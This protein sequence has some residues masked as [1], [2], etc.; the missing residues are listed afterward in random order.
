MATPY[1][2]SVSYSPSQQILGF[3]PQR[4]A[5]EIAQ[6]DNSMMQLAQ[7]SKTLGGE[8]MK[9]QEQVN[10]E[11][12]MEGYNLAL[13][14]PNATDVSNEIRQAGE[15]LKADDMDANTVAFDI[16]K[17]GES[18][19]VAQ[20][21]QNMSGWKRYGYAKGKAEQA[22]AGWL[23][24][25]SGQFLNNRDKT[26]S[27]PETGQEFTLADT[28]TDPALR[29]YA[30]T[31]MR[32][33]Y[34]EE[35]GLLTMKPAFLNEWA[36]EKFR[37]GQDKFVEE[38]RQARVV[39]RGQEISNQA[40]N[41]V[42]G[43]LDLNKYFSNKKVSYNDKGK[44]TTMNEA[45]N[46]L[47][48][49]FKDKQQLTKRAVDVDALR[50][51]P[52]AGD[53]K[54]RTYGDLYKAKLDGLEADLE[55]DYRQIQNNI[56]SDNSKRAKDAVDVILENCKNN[57]ACT[58]QA[59]Q[60]T[61]AD[62]NSTY[63]ATAASEA[64]KFL[65][66][67]YPSNVELDE[68]ES[69]SLL[70]QADDAL[71]LG[72]MT[73]PFYRSLPESI[74]QLPEVQER[75]SEQKRL[76]AVYGDVIS[77][78]ETSIANLFAPTVSGGGI[79]ASSYANDVIT[80]EQRKFKRGLV[81]QFRDGNQDI[82]G[83][84]AN[85][86]RQLQ[87]DYAADQTN[88]KGTYYRDNRNAGV[89]YPNYFKNRASFSQES[90]AGRQQYIADSPALKLQ[91]KRELLTKEVL[92]QF[93]KQ[94]E[95][96]PFLLSVNQES[97]EKLF[98]SLNALRNIAAVDQTTV[99]QILQDINGMLDAPV[100]LPPIPTINRS[101]ANDALGGSLL[102][103]FMNGTL[104]QR[105]SERVK[106]IVKYPTYVNPNL[107]QQEQQIVNIIGKYESDALGGY[108]AVNQRG[109]NKG[110]SVAGYS[111]PFSQMSQHGGRKLTELTVGEIMELQS[112]DGSL[113]NDQWEQ[114]GKL[115]AVGR[116]QFIGKTLAE[117]VNKMGI[118]KDALFSPELQDQ[119]CLFHFREK[120]YGPWVG[121]V[122][123]G[124]QTEKM[125]LN[126]ARI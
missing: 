117:V 88:D 101:A 6:K 27:H 16:I 110:R 25:L 50:T 36:G 113:T 75:Y 62:I 42:L 9:Y 125:F 2:E 92:E 64:V 63:G 85:Y 66:D 89:P 96:D 70:R 69:Q 72:E 111:G 93:A 105:Q 73:D 115:H 121:V 80:E 58:P 22:G 33:D 124:S 23:S 13:S 10:K 90:E 38:A 118:S 26:F 53:P 43:D 81:Q 7:F 78:N 24:Y 104:T 37:S 61:I 67:Q 57:P 82:I 28:E 123:G 1:E 54:G 65:T 122:D 30:I 60:D 84:A 76:N 59:L 99:H 112:D 31:E 48:E 15:Q 103:K 17:G 119:M 21:V 29:A 4:A 126:R 51:Q 35:N 34:L 77:A 71:D 94:M 18:P 91:A 12:M 55:T 32:K 3:S 40:E 98:Y 47:T 109:T 39:Q 52:I 20:A 83:W 11:Q 106:A 95:D 41:E 114:Q 86:V 97:N 19:E 68:T 8:L 74:K 45:W 102:N 44:L 100:N 49:V 79:A 116:Y 87:Q 107:T 56:R 108:D 46:D 120:G 14:E 5:R